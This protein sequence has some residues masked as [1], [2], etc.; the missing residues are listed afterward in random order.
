MESDGFKGIVKRL[1]FK[2]T[3]GFVVLAVLVSAVTCTIGYV[4]YRSTIERL[5]NDT[6]YMVARMAESYVDGDRIATYLDTLQT[7]EAYD[8]MAE[9]L[10]RLRENSNARYLFV[11]QP[12]GD[13]IHYIYDA[14]N[15]NMPQMPL[16]S[17]DPI[18]KTHKEEVLRI[19]N[20]GEL[21]DSY[22]ISHS[23][24]GY[25]TSAI[26]PIFSSTG[27]VTALL[28]VDIAMTLIQSTLREYLLTA[29]VLGT[30][31]VFVIVFVYLNY[32]S[33]KV[34]SPI[35]LITENA[36]GFVRNRQGFSSG[37]L[38]IHTGDEIETLAKAL[39]KMETDIN[40]YITNLAQVTAD[41]ERIATELSVATQ[42]QSS[43]LPCIFPAFPER[44][45]F[46][47]YATMHAAKE[48]GGDFYDFFL[49]DND[50]LAVVIADV[51]GKGVPAALF[52]VIAKTLI[53][54][55]A[56]LGL[57]P[58]EVFETVNNQLCESNDAGM[59]VTAFMGLLE[60][61]SGRFTYVNAGHNPPLV[62]RSGNTY[63]WLQMK[64]GF[65]LAGMEGMPYQ[66]DE[67]TLHAGDR[68]FLYTDGVT[69]ALNP[70]EEL[71][72]EDR[73]I[74]LFNSG[75]LE[76]KTLQ[77]AL[78]I[79]RS[80]IAQFASG[81]E[82]A[83]DITMLMLKI[84]DRGDEMAEL[85][86][87]ATLENLDPVLDFVN[88][89]M[90]AHECPMGLI[91]Q[92]DLAV[93]EIYVNI[94]HYAYAPGTGDATIRCGVSGDPLTVSIEFLDGGVPY[95]PLE[96]EDP[97]ITL[98]AEERD[99]GGLGIFMVKNLMDHIQYEYKDGK[100]ILSIQK[101]VE[102]AK[103]EETEDGSC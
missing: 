24:Y 17:T 11:Y 23:A 67:I 27:E 13:D 80:D 82:Q 78:G 102:K 81:A 79:V 89:Q 87:E 31:L 8:E 47:I 48:V 29:A 83:D 61:N 36:A 5:Y 1:S 53:K 76:G 43:M 32:L 62:A 91:T 39:G 56:Q 6:A 71:Y 2:F 55:H 9:N 52:M 19:F 95:N 103:G 54:N 72:S 16:G 30:L 38:S 92:V 49:V 57:S 90:E 64:P 59:F 66:Q 46:D 15:G 4:K 74:R 100:N 75:I 101:A 37:V 40:D 28:N 58:A 41:K 45:E 70:Q 25:N 97:D 94:A 96:R 33:R 20:T 60:L 14:K 12:I 7:D 18:S 77:E 84:N 50:R 69:E 35:R 88:E 93:E 98:S 73:L 42:I 22:F 10:D 65:V 63:E 26:I 51:S 44:P 85:T 68:L 21:S 86:L 34:I 99:I 3:L